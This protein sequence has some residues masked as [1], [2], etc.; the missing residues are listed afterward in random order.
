M[1][2]WRWID[3]EDGTHTLVEGE[4][5]LPGPRVVL[6]CGNI[7]SEDQDRIAA[8]PDLYAAC[9]QFI[10]V[11]DSVDGPTEVEINE[12]AGMACAALAKAKGGGR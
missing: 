1:T 10:K 12:A 3:D 8:A 2:E 6:K 4:G 5:P 7:D 11:F 9:E